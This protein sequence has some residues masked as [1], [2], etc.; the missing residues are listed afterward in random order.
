MKK[1]Q[2]LGESIEQTAVWPPIIKKFAKERLLKME[3][4]KKLWA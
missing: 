2:I 3:K 4:L 1:R